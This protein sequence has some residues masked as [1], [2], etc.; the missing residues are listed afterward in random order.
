MVHLTREDIMIADAKDDGPLIPENSDA[1]SGRAT[2]PE[3]SK[4]SLWE[5][6]STGIKV[7]LFIFCWIFFGIIIFQALIGMGIFVVFAVLGSIICGFLGT[8]A[9]FMLK[10]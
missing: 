5:N 7:V 8:V 4:N 6:V 2:K 9:A 3:Q 1:A 10:P